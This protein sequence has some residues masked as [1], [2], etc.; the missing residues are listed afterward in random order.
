MTPCLDLR[1]PGCMNL[2]SG[3]T[4]GVTTVLNGTGS[5]T[6]GGNGTLT[7]VGDPDPVGDVCSAPTRNQVQ[8]GGRNI[9]DL[10]NDAGVSWGAFMGGFDLT[11]QE[12]QRHHRLPAKF[13]LRI[14]RNQRRLHSA[15]R[16]LP[17]LRFHRQP[18]ARP[19]QFG[20]RDRT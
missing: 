11:D 18:H 4:N 14:H 12:F 13:H 15:P 1:L 9:G 16:F 17:V 2:V 3:Q 19:S 5:E 7:V 6:D 8:M 10:L 20:F